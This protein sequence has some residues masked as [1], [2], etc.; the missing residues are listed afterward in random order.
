M[1]RHIPV[2][3]VS[4][5][6]RGW[7]RY[8]ALTVWSNHGAYIS[9]HLLPSFV[10]PTL[11]S[12]VAYTLT[13]NEV[14]CA[15]TFATMAWDLPRTEALLVKQAMECRRVCRAPSRPCFPTLDAVSGPSMDDCRTF[16]PDVPEGFRG[17]PWMDLNEIGTKPRQ[18]SAP[19][20]CHMV[21]ESVVAMSTTL[22]S[23]GDSV[24][25]GGPSKIQHGGAPVACSGRQSTRGWFQSLG[26]LV[27]AA[28]TMPMTV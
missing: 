25:S 5:S 6:S 9:S 4:L 10:L 8:A 1:R 19:A 22:T 17:P 18:G 14:A 23:I 28:I 26:A 20:A 7:C 21:S 16:A 11:Y 15:Y 27:L 2:P 3:A 24:Q 12:F 13:V